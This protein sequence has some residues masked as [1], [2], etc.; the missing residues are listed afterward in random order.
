[1]IKGIAIYVVALMLL[2]S[3]THNDGDIGPL[4][5]TWQLTEREV[6]MVDVEES[7][8]AVDE[9]F[10]SF[11]SS[12]VRMTHVYSTSRQESVYGNWELRGDVMTLEFP[13]S[14]Q[15]MLEEFLLPRWCEVEVIELTGKNLTVVW[16]SDDGGEVKY[17]FKKR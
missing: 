10:W 4:F 5:G 13:D 14:E 2:C 6:N 7:L 12:V 1:M 11:Q 9:L 17:K 15:P 16:H 3:C 8:P